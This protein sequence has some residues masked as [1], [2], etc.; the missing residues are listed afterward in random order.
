M[1][2]TQ[3]EYQAKDIPTF[4]M[5]ETEFHH[6]RKMSGERQWTA[7]QMDRVF[8]GLVKTYLYLP[9]KSMTEKEMHLSHTMIRLALVE[10]PHRQKYRVFLC[11]SGERNP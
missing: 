4:D 1:V 5:F 3:A 10:H 11:T 7:E 6:W 8:I 9:V 2:K